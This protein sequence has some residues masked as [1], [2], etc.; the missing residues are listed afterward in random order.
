VVVIV[1]IISCI[2]IFNL[3]VMVGVGLLVKKV[4]EVGFVCKL[5]VKILFVFGSKV[6]M[7]YYDKFG[8]MLYLEKFGFY[9]VGYGCIICIG[10]FG[11]IID[12]VLVVVNDYDF[13]VILVLLGNCNFEGCINLD[14][15]M[16]YLVLLL[17]VIV[18]VF[19]GIMDFDF[20]IELFG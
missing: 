3:L 6:V 5:W 4:V 10:N 18:Y 8:F 16:N 13:V 17:L 12:E 20:E 1:L 11:L 9:F 19:V 15:K 2:N 7:G 14:V